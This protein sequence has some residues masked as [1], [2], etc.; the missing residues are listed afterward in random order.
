MSDIRMTK[1]DPVVFK[2]IP[3][4]KKIEPLEKVNEIASTQSMIK[5]ASGLHPIDKDL[6]E[7]NKT[8]PPLAPPSTLI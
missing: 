4:P 2:N 8:L 7:E 5:E 3:L 6:P 1:T